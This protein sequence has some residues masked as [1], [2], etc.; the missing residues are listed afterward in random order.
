MRDVLFLRFSSLGDV[1]L[2]TALLEALHQAE[3][4][5]RIWYATKPIYAPLF[6]HDD[7]VHR[8]VTVGPGLRGVME[9]AR[10]LEAVPFSQILDAPGSLRSRALTA[11]LPPAETRRIAKDAFARLLFVWTKRKNRALQRTAVDRYLAMLDDPVPAAPRLILQSDELERARERVGRGPLLAMAPGARHQPKRYPERG[12]V[13][14]ARRFQTEH[15]ARILI[16]GG[17]DEVELCETV[18]REL[19]DPVVL[20]PGSDLREVAAHL[21]C[22]SLLLC[23]DSGLMHVA[24]AVG[25]PVLSLFGPTSREFGF[26]PR[27]AESRVVEHALP[28]RPCSRTG[29]KPCAMPEQ[30]CLTRSTPTL[31]YGQLEVQWQR[32]T[33]SLP[34]AS[35]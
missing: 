23:N 25:T 33:G 14:V 10:E 4:S 18:A 21:A 20:A 7:R 27:L 8:V 28:C 26:F 30:W 16:V 3:P 11:L 22:A 34:P 32:I 29:A 24:E 13:E 6:E 35:T 19:D 2:S 5:T 1:V 31:V 15:P 12:Y 17:P 9:M